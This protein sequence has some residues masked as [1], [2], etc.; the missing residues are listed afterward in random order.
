MKLEILNALREIGAILKDLTRPAP[1]TVVIRDMLGGVHLLGPGWRI[2]SME[3]I[4]EGQGSVEW[5]VGYSGPEDGIDGLLTHPVTG[6][7]A[8]SMC[9][10]VIDW[11]WDRVESGAS[12]VSLMECELLDDIG[13][14]DSE[15]E[16]TAN[17]L[18]FG[19]TGP[20]G[21]A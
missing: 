16:A 8:E 15:A 11:I 9:D 6:P 18:R 7:D 20:M 19:F 14:D 13:V 12:M 2:A 10:S 17:V 5:C 4:P 21:E 3:C 1:A